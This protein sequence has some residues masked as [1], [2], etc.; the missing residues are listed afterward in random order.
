MIVCGEGEKIPY[1]DKY[2]YDSNKVIAV[3]QV[4]KN[5]FSKDIRDSYENL[6][7]VLEVTELSE[8]QPFHGIM[9]QDSWRSICQEELPFRDK[10]EDLVIEKQMLYHTLFL[11]TYYPARIAWG[12]NGF[13]SEYALRKSFVKYLESNV[14]ESEE[15]KKGFSP[16]NFPNL[17]I[18]DKYSLIKANGIPF[19]HPMNDKYW[20]PF[21][22]SSNYN[23]IYYLLEIIWSRLQYMFGLSAEIFGD[24]LEYDTMHGFLLGKFIVRK[25]KQGWGYI[26][27]PTTKDLL[28]KPIP[29]KDWEPNYLNKTQFRIFGRLCNG[30]RIDFNSDSELIN[31]VLDNGFSI[32][33]FLT[34][35]KKTGLVDIS[36]RIVTLITEQCVCGISKQGKFFAADN[37][38]GRVT[39]WTLKEININGI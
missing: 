38:T 3:I 28:Q 33:D 4:K 18:C 27:I 19:G 11:E 5:L 15:R 22:A 10:V 37:K 35:M 12:Y 7:T 36:N 30:E 25:E 17:I 1:T 34:E 9:L 32:D 16:L 2:V 24:D 31:L 21:Y 23:P 39:R 20:W 29:K 8:V 14:S 13:K 6:K 26:C